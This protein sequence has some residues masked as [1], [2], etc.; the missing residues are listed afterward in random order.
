MF[1]LIPHSHLS[2]GTYGPLAVNRCVSLSI[3]L[4][5][6]FLSLLTYGMTVGVQMGYS[7]ST[8][9]RNK[10]AATVANS[11]FAIILIAIRFN[12]H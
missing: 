3:A 5:Y 1:V 12:A 11:S 2:S 9:R 6:D 10:T 7:R 4:H 8:V